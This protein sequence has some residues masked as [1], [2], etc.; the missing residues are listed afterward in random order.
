[1]HRALAFGVFLR[2]VARAL[3]SMRNG[4][5]TKHN[6]MLLEQYICLFYSSLFP[7]SQ[8]ATPFHRVSRHY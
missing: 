7:F 2:G 4:A 3:L 6:T 1:M 5:R 8:T